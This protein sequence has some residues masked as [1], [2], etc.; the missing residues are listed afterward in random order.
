MRRK[1]VAG[2]SKFVKK[3]E[4]ESAKRNL[5]SKSKKRREGAFL[6]NIQVG[7]EGKG[8]LILKNIFVSLSSSSECI[9]QD[10]HRCASPEITI[11]PSD[12][13]NGIRK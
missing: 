13:N 11:R 2:V 9:L 3:I 6:K 10:Q 12:D 5:S 4:S 8:R 7:T 1:V